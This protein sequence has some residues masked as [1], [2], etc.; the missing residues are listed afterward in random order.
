M[1]FFGADIEYF[2][3]NKKNEIVHASSVIDTE[4]GR[5]GYD[6]IQG[7]LRPSP[8]YCRDVFVANIY[9]CIKNM[10]ERLQEREHIP[11]YRDFIKIKKSL[12]DKIPDK[13]KELGCEPDYNAY[14]GEMNPPPTEYI[15]K[16]IR[17]CGGHIHLGFEANNKVRIKIDNKFFITTTMNSLTQQSILYREYIIDGTGDDYRTKRRFITKQ[18]SISLNKEDIKAGYEFEISVFQLYNLGL[19]RY[20]SYFQKLFN[21]KNIIEEDIDKKIKVRITS[22]DKS[23]NL[24]ENPIPL[25]KMLDLLVG[26]PCVMLDNGNQAKRREIYGKAGSYRTK[27][28]GV[29]YR[30]LSNFWLTSKIITYFILGMARWA[31]EIESKNTDVK[32]KKY[33]KTREDEIIYAINTG[34][35]SLAKNIFDGMLELLPKKNYALKYPLSN[36]TGIISFKKLVL[37]G[38]ERN[39]QNF[40]RSSRHL[41][42]NIKQV[43]KLW[44]KYNG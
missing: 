20:G 6:G 24:L 11:D 8:T 28:Y 43:N 16:P 37:Y 5:I 26:I 4:K 25:I 22:I 33:R 40:Y 13:D 36:E 42:N 15:N 44:E 23:N 18:Y 7:E 17:T 14:T 1:I 27:K 19:I 21:R 10:N 39:L 35:K 34:D 29:E 38:T 3:R 41:D 9:Q 12:F 30:V 32:L 2:I 31:L